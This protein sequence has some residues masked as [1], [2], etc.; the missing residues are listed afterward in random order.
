MSNLA[1]SQKAFD[2]IR[3]FEGLMLTAYK[4]P[5]GILTIGYGHTGKDVVPGETIDMDTAEQLLLA[6]VAKI[7]PGLNLLLKVDVTQN[8]F[9]ALVSFTYNNGIGNFK[10]STMLQLINKGDFTDAAKEFGRW[11]FGAHI[12]LDGLVTRRLAERDLFVS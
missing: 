1:P 12:K 6:D 4:C 3:Q 8:Q 11:V 9:D 10:N 2:L 5:A 7:I